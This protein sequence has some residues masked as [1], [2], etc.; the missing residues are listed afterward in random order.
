MADGRWK[1]V[2]LLVLIF[3]LG[4]ATGGFG[5][6]LLESRGY[7]RRPA[8]SSSRQNRSEIV[9]KFTKELGLTS[10]QQ[11]QLNAI[12]AEQE[13]RF[14]DLNKSFRSQADV[15]RQEGRDKIRAILTDQQ[16]P[17]FDEIL[18]RFDEERRRR[19]ERRK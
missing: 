5:H 9:D 6:H 17:K 14:K 4:I 2:A 19:E 15:I 11:Q 8:H 18:K 7:F 3:L 13:Q 1:F 12:L 10:D 16:K